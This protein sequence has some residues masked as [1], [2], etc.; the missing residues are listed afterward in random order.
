VDSIL[1]TALEI[2]QLLNI[3]LIPLVLF[4]YRVLKHITVVE[5]FMRESK[6][7]RTHLNVRVSEHDRALSRGGLL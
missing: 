4:A 7:D 6:E 5:S 2:A 1:K 3:L